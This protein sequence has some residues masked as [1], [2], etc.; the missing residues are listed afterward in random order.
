MERPELE[1]LV[2]DGLSIRKIVERVGKGY[3]TVRYW[4]GV[5]GLKTK[6]V[7]RCRKCEDTDESHFYPGRYTIC[8][9]C[10]GKGQG[11]MYRKYKKQAIAYKGGEC[12]RC[13]YDKY[14][15]ALDFHHRDTKEK[16]PNWRLMRNWSFRRVKAEL[17]KCDLVCRNC[18]AEIHYGA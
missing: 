7:C 11:W 10:R 8:K 3:S 2:N 16:D 12:S 17:D 1:A 13:G 5:Y 6:L 9:K 4:L 14:Q 18:H 15:A